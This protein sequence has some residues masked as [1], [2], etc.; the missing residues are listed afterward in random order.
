[1]LLLLLSGEKKSKE[2]EEELEQQERAAGLWRTLGKRLNAANLL[3]YRAMI[4]TEMGRHE[5][6]RDRY[7]EAIAELEVGNGAVAR[8]LVD[9]FSRLAR[10][11]YGRT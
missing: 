2:E 1:M 11:V 4:F 5:D 9:A 8:S 3:Q 10:D 6:A 7:E